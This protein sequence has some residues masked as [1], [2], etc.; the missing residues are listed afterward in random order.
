MEE[1]RKFV[2]TNFLDQMCDLLKQSGGEFT[3]T[4]KVVPLEELRGHN[5]ISFIKEKALVNTLSE[6]GI[7]LEV[8]PTKVALLPGDEVYVINVLG[9]KLH[10]VKEE[11]VLPES[12]TL[13]VTRYR[14]SK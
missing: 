4:G 11:E 14:V 5:L 13:T 3:I 10:E 2:G 12:A 8:N 7:N 9:V 6:K 1:S